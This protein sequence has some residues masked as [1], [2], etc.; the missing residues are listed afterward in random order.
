MPDDDLF[1]FNLGERSS[2]SITCSLP[3]LFPPFT[4]A[5]LKGDI[6]TLHHVTQ[7]CKKNHTRRQALLAQDGPKSGNWNKALN[8][9]ELGPNHVNVC[10]C[11][12]MK[13][14]YMKSKESHYKNTNNTHPI[15]QKSNTHIQ[16]SDMQQT[17]TIYKVYNK[18]CNTCLEINR[19]HTFTWRLVKRGKR[20]W[21]IWEFVCEHSD[22]ER[23]LNKKDDE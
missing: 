21:R 10:E 9:W 3:S 13:T 19:T 14:L 18:I 8:S 1:L 17:H 23:G 2:T 15:H 20:I 16:L 5:L 22:V 4:A 12:S 7:R 6:D 11:V